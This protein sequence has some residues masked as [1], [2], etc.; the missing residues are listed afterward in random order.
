MKDTKTLREEYSEFYVSKFPD[1]Y[2][3]GEEMID[4]WINKFNQKLEEIERESYTKGFKDGF[5]F[6]EEG[7]NGEYTHPDVNIEDDL[8]EQIDFNLQIIKNKKN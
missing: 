2:P 4:W 6:S 1:R 8:K 7:F 5:S 3:T